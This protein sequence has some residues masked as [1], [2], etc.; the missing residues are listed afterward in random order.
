MILFLIFEISIIRRCLII[1][2]KGKEALF[3]HCWILPVII[4]G[5][6]ITELS[7]AMLFAMI[8]FNVPVFY[9]ITG[10]CVRMCRKIGE[11]NAAWRR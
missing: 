5:I 8:R 1:L 9:I 6:M 3:R 2:F 7:E 10:C 11:D 4:A